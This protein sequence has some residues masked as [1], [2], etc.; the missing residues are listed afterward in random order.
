MK[1]ETAQ[2]FLQKKGFRKVHQIHKRYNLTIGE[3]VEFLNEYAGKVL[4]NGNGQNENREK[5]N[6]KF[7]ETENE[8]SSR[9]SSGINT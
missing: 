9:V 3:L 4:K 5:S 1:M 8:Q 7:K 2:E 6:S